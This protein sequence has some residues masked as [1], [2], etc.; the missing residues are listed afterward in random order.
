[1]Q[2]QGIDALAMLEHHQ[3]PDP[4]RDSGAREESRKRLQATITKAIDRKEGYDPHY[5]IRKKLD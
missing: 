5:R 4:P 3:T 1:M 2:R